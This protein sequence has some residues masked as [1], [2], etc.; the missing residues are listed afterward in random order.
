MDNPNLDYN[1]IGKENVELEEL[2]CFV[3]LASKK[4][5]SKSNANHVRESKVLLVTFL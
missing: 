1:T 5:E 3:L 2:C 4:I